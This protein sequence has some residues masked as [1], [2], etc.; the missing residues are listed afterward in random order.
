MLHALA[1]VAALQVAGG[2]RAMSQLRTCHGDSMPLIQLNDGHAMPAVGLGT[3]KAPMKGVVRAAVLS[4]LEAGYRHIDCASVY[5]NEEE[6]GEALREAMERRI[7]RR[8]E[9]F[10]TSKLWN[11]DHAPEQVPKALQKTLD[12]LQLAYLDLYLVHWPVT[13]NPGPTLTP[14]TADTWHAME[15]LV[16]SGK[17]RS[18]G[19]S[20]FSAKKLSE[21][22]LDSRTRIRPAVNQ[23][24]LHPLHRQDAL[25]AR[26]REL[27]V[28][29][30]AY[31]PLGSAD[32]ASML[33]H[34]GASLLAHPAVVR[35]ARELGRTPAQV[36]VRWAVQRGT[37]AIPKSVQPTR[38]RDNLAVLSWELPAEQM[39]TLSA[40]EPQVRFIGGAFWLNNAGPYRTLAQLWDD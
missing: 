18:I 1:S 32:S 11:S 3:W 24:E 37:S 36:L 15:G 13:G 4:A 34:D 12:D 31:S 26:A 9:L 33:K 8:E 21:L 39:A 10:V 20:N 2:R 17:V 19:V 29:L 6:I 28:H 25:L 30:T 27:G 5:K 22:C 35:A 16:T 14:S 38:I 40:L 23:V 7:V